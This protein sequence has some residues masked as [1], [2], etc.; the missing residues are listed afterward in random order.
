MRGAQLERFFAAAR[1]RDNAY[2]FVYGQG[3]GNPLAHDG[4]VIYHKRANN[5]PVTQ[6]GRSEAGR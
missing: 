3:K 5:A 4:M 1:L 2:I 6:R